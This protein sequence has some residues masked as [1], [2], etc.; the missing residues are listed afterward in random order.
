MICIEQ[1]DGALRVITQCDHARHTTALVES[2]RRPTWFTPDTWSRFLTAA[3]RHEDGWGVAERM[4]ALDADGRP[5]SFAHLPQDAHLPIL[6]ASIDRVS[7]DDVY[8]GLLVA[9]H[10]RDVVSRH[11]HPDPHDAQLIQRFIDD[12]DQRID[13]G[14]A[15]LQSAGDAMQALVHP[16]HLAAAQRLLTFADALSMILMGGIPPTPLTAHLPI[17][18][19]TAP[20]TAELNG[21]SATVRPWPFTVAEVDAPVPVRT[22][23]RS[24]FDTPSD[25]ALALAAVEP[26]EVVYPVRRA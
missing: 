20:I 18:H 16:A 11:T 15:A 24:R 21:D 2:W 19:D 23:D 3:A 6:A 14:L 8:A 13:A 7:A 26:V 25:F 9:L 12:V 5:L 17:E 1:P 10:F 4:P 22:L